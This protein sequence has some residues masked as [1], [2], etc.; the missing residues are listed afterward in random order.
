MRTGPLPPQVNVGVFLCKDVNEPRLKA[1]IESLL[2]NNRVSRVLIRPHPKNLWLG[3]D[4]WIASHA[5]SRLYRSPGSSVL[6]DSKNLDVVFGG[7]SSVLV[8][9]VTAGLPS[10]Y[11]DDLDHGS[12]DLHGFVAQSLIYGSG[13]APDLNEVQRFYQRPGWQ[14]TL[15]RFA[16]IDD[17]ECAVL[18]DTVRAISDICGTLK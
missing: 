8:E 15:R 7:N 6:D 14:E 10:A 16:N 3:I 13:V 1:L 11:L 18:A 2:S 4:E 5:D 9:A 12:P 17:D